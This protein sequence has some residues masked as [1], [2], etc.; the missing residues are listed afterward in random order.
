MQRLRKKIRLLQNQRLHR[1]TY[2][3]ILILMPHSACNCRCVMCD[4]WKANA[5][6]TE[7]SADQLS[8]HL[9]AFQKLGVEWVILTGGEPLM[10]RNLWEFCR[11]LKRIGVRLTLLSS[12]LLL[13]PYA[14]EIAR[15]IDEVIV[16]LDGSPP[17]HNRI[18]NVPEAFEKLREGIVALQQVRPQL[19]LLA[20]CVVQK[21]NYHDLPEIIKTARSLNVHR[22]SFVAADVSSSAYNRPVPWSGEKKSEVMLTAEEVDRLETII[23]AVI[24]AFP[25]EFTTG[26]IAEPP[27]KLRRMVTYFRALLGQTAFPPVHCNA[28]WVSAVVEANGQVRP[29]FFHPPYGRISEAELPKLLNAPHA[30]AFRKH[31]RVSEH[32]TCQACTCSLYLDP[33]RP[34]RNWVHR[35]RTSPAEQ[36]L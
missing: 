28:P 3:P 2:L 22:L 8:G 15:W 30:V 26:F 24:Q 29:C 21:Q 27:E 4:I 13:K 1:I 36:K 23:E 14:R 9:S 5:R 6:K 7:L 18:R 19:T 35:L 17:V 12:G 25:H 20:R 32:P 11:L 33:I 34:V 10:H 31:L 16:S